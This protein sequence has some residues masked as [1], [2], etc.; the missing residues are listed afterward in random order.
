[1]SDPNTHPDNGH[2]HAPGCGHTRI[3]HSGHIDYL[4]DS[5]LHHP[6]GDAGSTLVEEHVLEISAEIPERCTP[7]RWTH[8]G[9]LHSG[10][11]AK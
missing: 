2:R 4:H 3:K 11:R 9:S 10:R 8:L 1:M 7:D 6:V 5:H